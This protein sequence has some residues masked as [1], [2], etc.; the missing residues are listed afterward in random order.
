MHDN[1]GNFC[2]A[3]GSVRFF[4]YSVATTVIRAMASATG[5][6]VVPSY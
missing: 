6:E 4:S 5:G 1:G 3:D 2:L